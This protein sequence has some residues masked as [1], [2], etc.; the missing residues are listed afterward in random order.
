MLGGRLL[1]GGDYNPDQWLEYP[2]VF[3]EDVRLMKEANVN[4]VSL[5]IFAWAVLEPEE[6]RYEL[7]W[8]DHIITRLGEEGIQVVLATPSGAMPNWLTQKYPEV[9]QVQADGHRNLPG[10]RHNFCYTS[11]VMREKIT[12][13]DRVLAERFG[14]R[15]NVILWHISNELGGN[16]GDSTCHCE[17]CQEAFRQWLKKKYG[18]LENLNSAWWNHF[19]SHTYTDWRQIHSPG[20]Y[21]ETTSTA[22]VLDWRRFSTEQISSFCELEIKTVKEASDLPA[23]TNFMD[24]FKGLD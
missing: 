3:E 17:L 4:C 12:S 5:G 23:T 15:D 20:P 2:E 14:R 8:M 24:F 7:D 16:F 11:P 13:I 22:L 21:G 10:K 1:H 9:M 6:G 18:T 19:W